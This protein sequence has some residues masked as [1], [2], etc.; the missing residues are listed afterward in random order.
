MKGARTTEQKPRA[1]GFK[2]VSP[3][4]RERLFRPRIV[5]STYGTQVLDRDKKTGVIFLSTDGKSLAATDLKKRTLVFGIKGGGK[6]AFI[7]PL[8]K[9][10]ELT[11]GDILSAY[12]KFAKV[13]I[14]KVSFKKTNLQAARIDKALGGWKS[15]QLKRGVLI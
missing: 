12:G 5:G 6:T 7:K 3:A 9:Q 4:T 14:P 8:T 10:A 11:T 1:S 15:D 13:A 2:K